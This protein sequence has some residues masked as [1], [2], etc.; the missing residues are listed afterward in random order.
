MAIYHAHVSS[1]SRSGGQ[2]GAAKVAYV[3]RQG[4]YAGR[5]DLVVSGHGNLPAWADGDPCALFAAADLYERK[6][7]RLF[8]EIEVALPNELREPQQHALVRAIAAAV[9]APGMPFT[10]AIHA[11]RQ[12]AEGVAENPHAHI[13]VSERVNDGIPRIPKLWFKRANRKDPGAGGAAKYRGMK[14]ASWVKDTRKV[15]EGLINE[16]LERARVAARVTSDSHATRI[17]KALAAGDVEMAVFLFRHPPGIHLGPTVAALERDRFSQKE[18]EAPRLSRA[19]EPTDRGDQHRNVAADTEALRLVAELSTESAALDLARAELRQAEDAVAAARSAGLGDDEIL[20]I[21]E[22]S[23]SADAGAG[24]GLVET[25]AAARVERKAAAE[26]AAGE[27]PIDVEALWQSA[28]GRGAD[29]VSVLEEATAAFAAART[30]LLPDAEVWRMHDAAELSEQGTGWTA[31]RAASSSRQAQ[32]GAAEAGAATFDLNAEGIYVGALDRGADPVAELA[33]LVAERE[34]EEA[35]RRQAE[36]ERETRRWEEKRDADI[37]ALERQPGGVDLY[38]AHLADLDPQWDRKRNDRSS[39]EHI[40]AALAAASSDGTR[41]ERLRVVLSDKVDAARYRE[42]LGKVAGQFKTSDLDKVLAVVEQEREERETRQWE[43]QRDAGFRALSRQ[44]GGVDLYHAHLADFDPQWDRKRNAKSSRQNIDAALAA[45]SSDGTRLK[46]LRVVLSNEVDAARYREELDKVVGQFKMSDLDGALAVAEQ[47]RET[48]LWKEQRDAGVQALERQPG[49]RDLY[50]AYLADFDP[51]W[52]PARN[53]RSLRQNIDAALAAAASD[54]ERLGRLRDVLAD[55]NDAACYRAALEKRGDRFTVEDIDA[56]V[57]AALGR[58][59]AVAARQREEEEKR[60]REVKARRA[61]LLEAL[62][63]AGRKLHAA[64]LVSLSPARR[65]GGGPAGADVDRALEATASD[66]R[67]PRLEAVFGDAEHLSYYRAVL[68]AAGDEV[69]L[70][71]ID[72]ALEATETFVR[73]KQTVFG[74]PGNSEHLA[75]GALYAAALESRA[76]G[77]RPGA[78]IGS[79]VFDEVLMDVESQLA[80]RVRQAADAVE[81]LLPTTQPL[82]NFRPGYR[83]PALGNE[84]LDGLVREDD[85]AFFKATV[86]A[87]RKRYQRRAGYDLA[88]EERYDD[89]DRRTSQQAYLQDAVATEQSSSARP[90]W[91]AALATVLKKYLSKIRELF[92]IACDKVLG[93]DLGDRLARHREQVR[94]AADAAVAAMPAT[95]PWLG[96]SAVPAVSDKTLTAVAVSA[97]TPFVKEVAIEVGERYKRQARYDT[98]SEEHYDHNDRCQSEKGYLH[99]TIERRRLRSPRSFTIPSRVV[100]EAEV[101]EEHRASILKVFEVACDEVVGRGDL[102]KRVRQRREQVRRVADAVVQE[103]PTQSYGRVDRHVPAV[104]DETLAA[105]RA[106]ADP[107]LQEAVDVVWDRYDQCADYTTPSVERYD[108]DDRRRSEEDHLAALVEQALE[109][110]REAWR[111]S[112]RQAAR[113]RVV[114][115][116]RSRIRGIF[117]ATHDEVLRSDELQD[118]REQSVRLSESGRA[119][120]A[121][122][123][124]RAA[125]ESLSTPPGQERTPHGREQRQGKQQ[126]RAG[127]DSTTG[128]G[129]K[130]N[131]GERLSTAAMST[132]RPTT[133]SVTEADRVRL[134]AHLVAAKLP[135][136]QPYTS[137]PSHRP[138][139]LSDERFNRLA[140]ATDDEFVRKVIA[141]VQKE[142]PCYTDFERARSEEA[143]LRQAIGRK[144]QEALD[145]YE[146]AEAKRWSF[147][148]RSPKPT[149][150]E[151]EAAA[152]EEFESKQ[153]VVIEEVCDDVQHRMPGAVRRELQRR[154]SGRMSTPSPS[155]SRT[156]TTNQRD[157]GDSGF[158]R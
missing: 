133:A 86:A 100:V 113:E 47:E 122:T 142:Q 71:Q 127:P 13:L 12:K 29:P 59:A 34:R 11:G 20:R 139:A 81:E 140:T 5:Y 38:H 76:T 156:R 61:D 144:H 93:G 27:F 54:S 108:A 90:L 1:G 2:S 143:Y 137:S 75:G 73:R 69:T 95:S 67:L 32:K 92:R 114:K 39:R 150:A 120:D 17:R 135:R 70:Q 55:P 57:E 136:T 147:S 41:L 36:Q 63:P 85:D 48:R 98:A 9:T 4:R 51:A 88:Y 99:D 30:T 84:L 112:A 78:E 8:V 130:D 66:V 21:Y 44:P 42:E 64:W 49:G 94:R 97:S 138:P 72:E 7:G 83:V 45:A 82:P 50:H 52:D 131:R 62:S 10:Y 14:D 53:A 126:E 18:G 111:T 56:A 37:Q 15:I 158:S 87:L 103:L 105:A 145:E 141:G 91:S 79:A 157:R 124:R 110:A 43:E 109:G 132:A 151:V 153:L 46:R 116:H 104:S 65:R 28:S 77:W 26:T 25:A 22:T 155:Q 115:D 119:G 89:H 60:E 6:N 118:Q 121:G 80:E 40:D 31:V 102:G 16:H 129:G 149:W 33:R 58:R 35:E 23:E 68:S 146:K 107:F 24:W 117:T 96:S 3:L 106:G 123:S 148:R 101:F 128:Q 134:A 74:Y 152:I 125:S 19:G 154:E